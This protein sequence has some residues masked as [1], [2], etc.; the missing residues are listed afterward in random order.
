MYSPFSP[1]LH[2]VLKSFNDT[3]FQKLYLYSEDLKGQTGIFDDHF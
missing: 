2:Q 3:E 1:T